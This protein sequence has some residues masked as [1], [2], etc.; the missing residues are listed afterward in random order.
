M[1]AGTRDVFDAVCC[2]LANYYNI[3]VIIF[4]H[5]GTRLFNDKAYDESLEYNDR[6]TKTLIV[7]A[8]KD[9]EKFQ[10]IKTKVICMGSMQQFIKNQYLNYKP[11]KDIFFCIGPDTNNSFRHLLEYYSVN[12]K[13]K[14]SIEILKSIEEKKLSVDLKLHPSGE[15]NSL[16]N[17]LNII[18]DFGFT[19]TKIIYGGAAEVFMCNYKLIILDFLASAV[20]K[21][22]F[23]LKTPIIIYD[24]DFDK[25]RIS[26]E[27]LSDLSKRCYI[28]RNYEELSQLLD[29]YKIGKLPS[30]WNNQIIDDYIYPIANGNPGLKIIEYIENLML[31]GN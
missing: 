16:I 11:F 23:S 13:Y 20:L 14:Q 15:K 4:Q 25:M 18:K 27:V 19:N 24:K 8:K 9:I 22:I 21:Q 7:H 26:S 29:K 10:N 17:Y 2:D 3:P 1:G 31:N 6:V 28:A 30:K 5:G 12:K